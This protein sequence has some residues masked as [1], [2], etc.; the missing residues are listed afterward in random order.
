[1]YNFSLVS[2]NKSMFA[3]LNELKQDLN[4]GQYDIGSNFDLVSTPA[5]LEYMDLPPDEITSDR[6]VIT[7]ELRASIVNRL[8][9]GERNLVPGLAL[10]PGSRLARLNVLWDNGILAFDTVVFGDIAL[11]ALDDRDAMQR[12]T[13]RLLRAPPTVSSFVHSDAAIP[14]KKIVSVRVENKIDGTSIMSLELTSVSMLRKQTFVDSGD[15]GGR[16]PLITADQPLFELTRQ[17]LGELYHGTLHTSALNFFL[18]KPTDLKNFFSHRVFQP[19]ELRSGVRIEVKS[20]NFTFPTL[21]LGSVYQQDQGRPVGEINKNA[22]RQFIYASEPL[23][24]GDKLFGKEKA[25]HCL[26]SCEAFQCSACKKMH[27]VKSDVSVSGPLITIVLLLTIPGEEIQ[28]KDVKLRFVVPAPDPNDSFMVNGR[29]LPSSRNMT[30]GDIKRVSAPGESSTGGT[31]NPGSRAL[32]FTFASMFANAKFL[33]GKVVSGPPP[34][35]ISNKAGMIFGGPDR[36]LLQQFNKRIITAYTKYFNQAAQTF[37]NEGDN[38]AGDDD[39]EHQSGDESSDDDTQHDDLEKLDPFLENASNITQLII[40]EIARSLVTL[41]SKQSRRHTTDSTVMEAVDGTLRVFLQGKLDIHR[42]ASEFTRAIRIVMTRVGL[43]YPS[44]AERKASHGRT[45]ISRLSSVWNLAEPDAE[46]STGMDAG[47]KA[48]RAKRFTDFVVNAVVDRNTTGDERLALLKLSE[49]NARFELIESENSSMVARLAADAGGRDLLRYLT[50]VAVAAWNINKQQLATTAVSTD[51]WKVALLWT[52]RWK[53]HQSLR[54]AILQ[55]AQLQFTDKLNEGVYEQFKLIVN[56]LESLVGMPANEMTVDDVVSP[57]LASIGDTNLVSV[58]GDD[59]GAYGAVLR[60]LGFA[61]RALVSG[62]AVS[63]TA[64]RAPDYPGIVSS[65]FRQSVDLYRFAIQVNT[66]LHRQQL[67]ERGAVHGFAEEKRN[68]KTVDTVG[69]ACKTFTQKSRKRYSQILTAGMSLHDI[70]PSA[71]HRGPTSIV[72]GTAPF[73]IYFGAFIPTMYTTLNRSETL[74]VLCNNTGKTAATDASPRRGIQSAEDPWMLSCVIACV[75][76]SIETRSIEVQGLEGRIAR[77]RS[78]GV[79]ID[80]P[81]GLEASRTL[82][83]SDVLAQRWESRSVDPVHGTSTLIDVDKAVRNFVSDDSI[84]VTGMRTA[85][86]WLSRQAAIGSEKKDPT[87]DNDE[88]MLVL[89][90]VPICMIPAAHALWLDSMGS[91]GYKELCGSMEKDQKDVDD[92]EPFKPGFVSR[93]GFLTHNVYVR[94]D[95]RLIN[96]SCNSSRLMQAVVPNHVGTETSSG[97]VHP[98]ILVSLTDELRSDGRGRRYDNPVSFRVLPLKQTILKRQHTCTGTTCEVHVADIRNNTTRQELML[99]TRR[100][101]LAMAVHIPRT[102]TGDFL[103]YSKQPYLKFIDSTAFHIPG[104]PVMS[105]ATWERMSPDDRRKNGNVFV[106]L[107]CFIRGPGD[108]AILRDRTNQRDFDAAVPSSRDWVGAHSAKNSTN[109]AGSGLSV[110]MTHLS[111]DDKYVDLADERK[112]MLFHT[113]GSIRRFGSTTTSVCP[114][115]KLVSVPSLQLTQRGRRVRKKARVVSDPISRSSSTSLVRISPR[116]PTGKMEQRT[117]VPHSSVVTCEDSHTLLGPHSLFMGKDSYP[118]AMSIVLSDAKPP[119]KGRPLPADGWRRWNQSLSSDLVVDPVVMKDGKELY[120]LQPGTV[121]TTT[122]AIVGRVGD[123][124]L[125]RTLPSAYNYGMVVLHVGRSLL[126]S[127]GIVTY[128]FAMVMP[129]LNFKTLQHRSSRLYQPLS[130]APQQGVYEKWRQVSASRVVVGT[131]TVDINLGNVFR[132]TRDISIGSPRA[133]AGGAVQQ[134]QGVRVSVWTTHF[135]DGNIHQKLTYANTMT[136]AVLLEAVVLYVKNT[137]RHIQHTTGDGR[138]VTVSRVL[139]TAPIVWEL[140]LGDGTTRVPVG[141]H[142]NC[143]DWRIAGFV[144]QDTLDTA[145]QRAKGSPGM[146]LRY[147]RNFDPPIPIDELFFAM[148]HRDLFNSSVRANITV[149]HVM[150]EVHNPK[151][152]GILGGIKTMQSTIQRDTVQ[153]ALARSGRT[154]TR[155]MQVRESGVNFMNQRVI[156]YDDHDLKKRGGFGNGLKYRMKTPATKTEG[157]VYTLGFRTQHTVSWAR[158]AYAMYPNVKTV[159]KKPGSKTTVIEPSTLTPVNGATNYRGLLSVCNTSFQ[160]KHGKVTVAVCSKCH[161]LGSLYYECAIP[162]CANNGC[163]GVLP[164]DV[165]IQNNLLIL[166]NFNES[167]KLHF[168]KKRE[169]KIK[170]GGAL[171]NKSGNVDNTLL[172]MLTPGS[173]KVSFDF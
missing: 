126:Q 80:T 11:K 57:I 122:T 134:E 87:L 38:G 117:L 154:S 35:G 172:E 54:V 148:E 168:G 162:R 115:N 156:V 137:T 46:T 91:V 56:R 71:G 34:A 113:V 169:A 171:G 48:K 92:G 120:L 141:L 110:T 102:D 78:H 22:A 166:L 21:Q 53:P 14:E 58:T 12:Y 151:G 167:V 15:V 104:K 10:P 62:N 23:R 139:Y 84:F 173:R 90:T 111:E 25:S 130:I 165:Q 68:S 159:R 127:H 36:Q 37:V 132:P 88:Y 170:Y 142:H 59:A 109:G 85:E 150:P 95:A 7:G 43:A 55:V 129:T 135:V 73:N 32:K 121:L 69:E 52:L 103:F 29:V 155:P 79:V 89:N 98:S 66:A 45:L 64:L 2:E 124:Y 72:R 39:D 119:T 114:T 60:S 81:I 17:V 128:W 70:H 118:R 163:R 147:E 9:P 26:W 123:L 133:V 31:V 108:N 97:T 94:H 138:A 50:F 82:R 47:N 86:R 27:K 145:W 157:P 131:P 75:L 144:S 6:E 164:H 112:C 149:A 125:R 67:A 93:L 160:P 105:I 20:A 8:F 101:Q 16:C 158:I 143:R 136:C 19:V 77:W 146:K 41:S 33:L 28:T 106:R 76:D 161:L 116:L 42:W 4:G 153:P 83:W 18:L 5:V 24:R 30:A 99:A 13:N 152:D 49:R 65:F 96:V 100:M 1:M 107:S 40:D 51:Y 44:S 74:P 61:C 63:G 140:E 3:A